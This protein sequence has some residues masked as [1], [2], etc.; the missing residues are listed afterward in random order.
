MGHPV[1]RVQCHDHPTSRKFYISS[2]MRFFSKFCGPLA[3]LASLPF[4]LWPARF[5]RKYLTVDEFTSRDVG[6]IFLW[7]GGPSACEASRRVQSI[8]EAS[9]LWQG[10]WGAASW[11]GLGGRCPP[12]NF[13]EIGCF[14]RHLALKKFVGQQ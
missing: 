7:G 8:C 13:C 11:R 9:K 12:E 10:S 6:R 3:S 14:R 5:A 1:Y 2:Q 4:Y